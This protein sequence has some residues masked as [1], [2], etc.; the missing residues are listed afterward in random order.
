MLLDFMSWPFTKYRFAWLQTLQ[1][2]QQSLLKN[3]DKNYR[4]VPIWIVVW[5]EDFKSENSFLINALTNENDAIP[6]WKKD[7]FNNND[8]ILGEYVSQTLL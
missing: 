4:A 5:N 2:M 1:Y 6:N 7:N 8:D 3:R